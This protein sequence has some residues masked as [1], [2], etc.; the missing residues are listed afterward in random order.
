MIPLAQRSLE[1]ISV[2]RWGAQCGRMEIRVAQTFCGNSV[3]YGH[4]LLTP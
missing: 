3:Q 4:C 1:R 2:E